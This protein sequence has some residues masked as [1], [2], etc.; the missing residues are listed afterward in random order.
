LTDLEPKTHRG[1]VSLLLERYER[2]GQLP[3]G[4]VST[5]ARLQ[6]FRGLA[7]D[8]AHERFS[9]ERAQEEIAAARSFVQQVTPPIE[10]LLTELS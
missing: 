7:D 9:R 1:V 2:P 4:A 6:T 5:L 10:R 3:P 8:D